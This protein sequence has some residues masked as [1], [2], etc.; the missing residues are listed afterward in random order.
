MPSQPVDQLLIFVYFIYGLAFFGMGLTLA[1]ESE[2][3]PTLAQARLIRPLAGFGMVHG[4]HEWL[5]SYL[6]LS[7]VGNVQLPEWLPWVRLAFLVVSFLFLMFYGVLT[8]LQDPLQ[9]MTNSYPGL[10][11]LG[12]YTIGILISAIV[13]YH[14]LRPSWVPVLDGMTRYLLAVPGGILAAMA[15]RTEAAAA[16][17]QKQDDMKV[18]LTWAAVGFGLYSLTQ[19]F[20]APLV[21]F[22]AN[23]INSASF[24]SFTGF[25][26]QIVRTLAAVTIT[27]SILRAT[28]AKEKER[29]EQLAS[30]QKDRLEAL[31][32][33][34]SELVERENLRRELL[35]HTVQAQEDERARIARELHDETSQVLAAFTLDLAAL[36]KMITSPAG[37]Q[38]LV[39]QL[40]LLSKQ[41]S[42][43]LYRLVHDLRPAQLDD[44]GLIPALDYLREVNISKSLNVTM[45]VEGET[46]R[47][48]PAVETVFFRVA[49]EALTNTLRHARTDQAYIN[50]HYRT[51]EIYMT[52]RDFGVGFDPVESFVPPRGWGLAGMRE[53]VDAL[54]GELKIDSAPGKGTSIEVTIPV[55]DGRS[56]GQRGQ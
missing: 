56:E 36:G 21:M 46:R 16:R 6:L 53:R 15:L 8:L 13:T 9:K 19:V 28:Q 35:R 55:V 43:A 22:P 7:Q 31:E 41:M 50:L 5:E 49:Q 47:L 11:V 51:N 26:I 12:I 20:V 37:A 2:R 24:R 48:D 4:T 33:I 10:V 25:P 52:V 30:A 27:I 32:R 39:E 3:S 1:L 44:L 18:Y 14:S 45:N 40:R 17:R 42:Q 23:I 38:T 29:Q 54:G 34:Q